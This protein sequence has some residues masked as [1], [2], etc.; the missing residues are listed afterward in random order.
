MSVPSLQ[1]AWLHYFYWLPYGLDGKN[2]HNKLKP[3]AH[4]III[5]LPQDGFFTHIQGGSF[6]AWNQACFRPSFKAKSNELELPRPMLTLLATLVCHCSLVIFVW[7]QLIIWQMHSALDD[8][9]SGSLW[10]TDFDADMY[11]DI[12]IVTIMGVGG[13]GKL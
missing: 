7:A 12:Y 1:L 8:Y 2:V 13:L 5:T 4:P 11:E 3:S 6:A 10:K 9:S